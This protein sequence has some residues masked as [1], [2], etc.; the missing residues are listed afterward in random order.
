MSLIAL[1]MLSDDMGT[2]QLFADLAD[3]ISLQGDLFIC[4]GLKAKLRLLLIQIPDT[5]TIH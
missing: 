3:A 1:W 5:N 4:G 2:A